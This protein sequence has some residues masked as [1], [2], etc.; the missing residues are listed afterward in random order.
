MSKDYAKRFNQSPVKSK[1]SHF[2]KWIIAIVILV[3]LVIGF[4][5]WQLQM[6]RKALLTPESPA[7]HVVNAPQQEVAPEQNSKIHFEFYTMLSKNK[8]EPDHKAPLSFS[9]QEVTSPPKES[10]ATIEAVTTH[11]SAPEKK[12]KEV[13]SPM[14]TSEKALD[15]PVFKVADKAPEKPILKDKYILQLGVFSN[16]AT[17]DASK[18]QL[19]SLGVPVFVVKDITNGKV[20]YRVQAGPFVTKEAAT[21]LQTKLAKSKVQSI[22]RQQA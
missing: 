20:I 5:F 11:A 1:S 14:K 6:H 21:Q 9:K 15:K 19:G 2:L 17:A 10:I 4:R 18:S 22:V 13:A 7:L 12:T 3:L 8:V 16:A